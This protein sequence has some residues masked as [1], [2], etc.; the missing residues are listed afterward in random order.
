M[1]TPRSR[2]RLVVAL[3]VVAVGL[4]GA[5][6]GLL[7]AGDVRSSVGPFEADLSLRPAL[8][9]ST[10]VTIP[11]LGELQ[12]DTHASPVRLGVSVT[13][14]R[15]QAARAIAAAELGADVLETRLEETIAGGVIGVL[16]AY[17]ILSSS[18]KPA[19]EA[20]VKAGLEIPEFARAILDSDR[21][22]EIG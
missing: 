19:L 2:H 1:S 12:L 13:T 22:I 16:C 18:S 21:V 7:V 14:L 4:L 11:P 20:K 9:G 15:E 10:V 5:L 17:L 3:E 8:T 6:L